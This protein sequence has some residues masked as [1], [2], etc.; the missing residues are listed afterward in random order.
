MVFLL[1]KQSFD[2]TT[3]GCF[4]TYGCVDGVCL[5]NVCHDKVV[6]AAPCSGSNRSWCKTRLRVQ[7]FD[8]VNVVSPLRLRER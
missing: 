6:E 3:Y 8:S 2:V 7:T 4:Q 5:L 1:V